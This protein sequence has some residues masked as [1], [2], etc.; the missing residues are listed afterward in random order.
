MMFGKRRRIPRHPKRNIGDIAFWIVW[1]GML[2]L[3]LSFGAFVGY[4]A[5]QMY[6]DP[7]SIGRLIGEIQRGYEEVIK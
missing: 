2:I 4:N 5:Y 1:W 6:K 7:A 3:I